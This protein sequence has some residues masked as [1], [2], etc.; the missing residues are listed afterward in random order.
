MAQLKTQFIM[1]CK[2]AEVYMS[3]VI[4]ALYTFEK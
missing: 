4:F 2:D 1:K 3:G